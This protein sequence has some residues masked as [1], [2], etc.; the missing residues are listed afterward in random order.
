MTLLEVLVALAIFASAAIALGQAAGTHLRSLD[1]LSST[2]Y[3]NWVASNRMVD[4]ALTRPKGNSQGKME[5][6]GQT[7]YWKQKVLK[8]ATGSLQAVQVDVFV[9]EDDET[10]LASLTTYLEP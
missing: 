9:N 7:W 2:T 3:A 4:V 1:Y 10:P 8:T 5:M 6:A